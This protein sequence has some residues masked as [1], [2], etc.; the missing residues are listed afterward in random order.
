MPFHERSAFAMIFYHISDGFVNTSGFFANKKPPTTRGAM[1]VQ[2]V[3]NDFGN[4]IPQ[5]PEK[6]THN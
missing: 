2:G 5:N 4:S 1:P 3:V 6:S